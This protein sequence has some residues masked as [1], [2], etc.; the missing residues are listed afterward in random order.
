MERCSQTSMLVPMS[1]VLLL[2]VPASPGYSECT[3]ERNDFTIRCRR[4]QPILELRF[5]L[6]R[7]V[8]HDEIQ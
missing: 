7:L 3:L 8:C 4:V 5:M 1:N 2:K 6:P